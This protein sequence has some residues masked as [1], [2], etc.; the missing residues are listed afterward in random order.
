MSR[1]VTTILYLRLD[2]S[3]LDC[4][5]DMP[6]LIECW[7]AP[8]IDLNYAIYSDSQKKEIKIELSTFELILVLQS[9]SFFFTYDDLTSL[10]DDKR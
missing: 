8:I 7:E 5:A 4:N 2:P 1:S 3:R 9:S 10:V 6:L